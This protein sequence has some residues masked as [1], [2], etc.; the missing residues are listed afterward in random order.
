[1]EPQPT[2]AVPVDHDAARHLWS[3]YAHQNPEAVALCPE[4]TVEHFG[5]SPA[6]ADVLLGEVLRGRKR[7]TA[8]LA[9]EFAGRGDAVPRVGSHWIAC[10]GAGVPRVVLRSVE[11]RLGVFASADAAFAWDEGEDDRS[12][13]SWRNEHRRYWQRGCA[14]RGTTWRES[15]EIVFERFRVVWPP[16]L[17]DV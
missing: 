14:A 13:E 2:P 16:E 10:D 15:D 17:A 7:A 11:L 12:L 8:E 4:Y 5:D 9:A 6:L 1:M 3:A